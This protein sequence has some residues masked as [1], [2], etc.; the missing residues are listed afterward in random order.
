[1]PGSIYLGLIAGQGMGPAAEW[2][3]IILFMEIARRSYQIAQKA[4]NL[5]AVLHRRGFNLV[6]SAGIAI[7]G[8]PFAGLIWNSYVVH[9]PIAQARLALHPACRTWV[10]PAPRFAWNCWAAP[11]FTPIGC[12][13]SAL[14]MFGQLF[15]RMTSWGLGYV[16]FRLTS[17]V[18]RLPF[19]L[20]PIAA[21][22]A[23]ALWLNRASQKE[24]WRWRIFSIGAMMG[25]GWGAL[26]IL[27][28]V[29]HGP[30]LFAADH[31]R[32]DSLH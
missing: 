14:L 9:T 16:L 15:G 2:V 18:E 7:S 12:P 29:R 4:G 17:D 31:A 3:T 10:S 21:E 20:A 13:P 26:Y 32:F 1:M 6:T 25:V 11:S 27:L 28:A 19:P 30:H 5:P 22:G 24:G 23:T 8:G